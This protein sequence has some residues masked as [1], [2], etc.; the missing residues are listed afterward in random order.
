M[1]RKATKMFQDKPKFCSP[2]QLYFYPPRQ[3]SKTSNRAWNRSFWQHWWHLAHVL[4]HL[5]RYHKVRNT[6]KIKSITNSKENVHSLW[7][8]RGNLGGEL[9]FEFGWN[10]KEDF[11]KARFH[12]GFRCQ[13]RVCPEILASLLFAW[14]CVFLLYWLKCDVGARALLSDRY[15]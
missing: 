15:V 4:R 1:I 11:R 8:M 3:N 14:V 12:F 13:R 6:L 10:S 2:A 5:A 9:S 7:I